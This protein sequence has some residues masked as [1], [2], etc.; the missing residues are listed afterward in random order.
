MQK[1]KP[2]TETNSELPISK[3]EAKTAYG[4]I[5]SGKFNEDTGNPVFSAKDT[6]GNI[7]FFRYT[8]T[9]DKEKLKLYQLE[10]IHKWEKDAIFCPMRE[11][12]KE[13][14]FCSINAHRHK[15]IQPC[16]YS[17]CFARFAKNIS[18]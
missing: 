12:G 4:A 17:T 13:F 8:G 18:G 6:G 5:D 1:S 3:P 15:D 7:P 11:A 9:P 10:Q 2:D 14:A 16:E